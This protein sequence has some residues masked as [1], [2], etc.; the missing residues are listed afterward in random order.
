M[1]LV[2]SS[3][4]M[5]LCEPAAFHDLW[6]RIRAALPAGGRFSGQWYGVRDSWHGRPGMTFVAKD[7]AVALLEGLE[8][9]MFDEE[10]SDGVTPRGNAKHWHIFHV[11]ARK[12]A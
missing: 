1:Q 10:E 12:P 4:A 8:I 11:V 5:P 7:E 2:N 6:Q 9:E 3:F